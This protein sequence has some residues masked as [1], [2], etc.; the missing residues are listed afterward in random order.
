[1]N[2]DPNEIEPAAP[3]KAAVLE[4]QGSG[5]DIRNAPKNYISLI[6]FQVWSAI[7]S[8]SAVWV[9]T[10]PQH[11]GKLG[12]GAVVA[13]IIASQVAQ[14][15]VNWT[16]IAVVRFG[17]DEFVETARI[18]RT[19]W[20]RLAILLINLVLVLSLANIW[21]PPLADWLQLTPGSFWLVVVH[22]AVTALWT[23]VQMSLQGAKMLRFQGILQM[24]ERLVILIGILALV[25]AGRLEFY[26]TVICYIAAPVVMFVAGII[27]LRGFIFAR[28]SS[29]LSFVKTILVYS[30]PL[31]PF[32][33]VGYF[34]GSY[35]DGIFVRKF[36]SQADLGVYSIATQANGIAM[37]IPTL[38][39]TILLPL[40]LTLQAESDDNR[41]FNYF[42]NILPAITLVWGIACVSLAFMGYF[43]IPIVYGSDFGGAALPMWV[44]LAASVASIP[45]AIGY[46]ALANSTSRTYVPMIAAIISAGVNVGA[47]F[48]LIPRYGLAGCAWATL[49]AYFFSSSA[50][51]LLL[52]GSAK[53][54]ISWT[55][56][57]MVP[58]I[59]GVVII[60]FYDNPLLAFGGCL[61]VSCLVG[62]F[63][64]RSLIEIYLFVSGFRRAA[65][66]SH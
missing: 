62:Y 1:M 66:E 38:A 61:A 29:D 7:F 9:I 56:L 39:N 51:A 44:L 15:L 59:F 48:A 65:N 10:R 5:W 35:V 33:L 4:R 3:E 6:L 37:Q 53:M 11:L 12:Y 20:V 34:S 41:T 24:L 46:S 47:N 22:F 23:H 42:R 40:L 60:S 36:L 18:A 21:F 28:F 13:V 26:G 25:A 57:A 45:V 43:L 14:V 52:K 32:T 54:P 19:F 49:I 17:V 58:S 8:F 64:K 30:L 55:F 27:M 50:F 2:P 31:L 16:S 63:Q